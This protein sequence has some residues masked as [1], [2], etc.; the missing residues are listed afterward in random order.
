MK[1]LLILLLTLTMLLPAALAEAPAAATI[2]M[3]ESGI[4]FDVPADWYYAV[5]GQSEGSS[6]ANLFG[7]PGTF[8][9]IYL[10]QNS[11]NFYATL[12]A[13]ELSRLT[14]TVAEGTP[15][16]DMRTDKVDMDA[17]LEGFL[18]TFTVGTVVDSSVL[19]TAEGAFARIHCN[20]PVEGG[21]AELLVY[22]CN[23]NATMYIFNFV[24]LPG[25]EFNEAELDAI[26]NS[27]DFAD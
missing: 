5:A 3:P 12:D 11:Y 13:M 17:L 18:T 16:I 25:G 8:L 10:T 1:R 24:A 19:Q 22:A 15:L 6:L 7:L 14:L 23:T 2:S 27:I 4:T 26:I 20:A 9:D 21:T